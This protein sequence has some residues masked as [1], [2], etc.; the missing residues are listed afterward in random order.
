MSEKFTIKNAQKVIHNIPFLYKSIIISTVIISTICL[1]NISVIKLYLYSSVYLNPL[2]QKK[3]A[4][5]TEFIKIMV[6]STKGTIAKKKVAELSDKY[7][8]IR[9]T[10]WVLIKDKS[11]EEANRY[12][13]E[14]L[15]KFSY[16]ENLGWDSVLIKNMSEGIVIGLN[17]Q[18]AEN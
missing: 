7:F 6:D 10:V 2:I 5:K 9:Y 18:Y 12:I 16:Q 8:D 15:N 14:Q 17:I 1:S 4:E 3:S 13:N 11:V